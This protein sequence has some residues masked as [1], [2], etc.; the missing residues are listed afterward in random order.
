MFDNPTTDETESDTAQINS[1]KRTSIKTKI[2][3]LRSVDSTP[4]ASADLYEPGDIV[5]CKLGGF[6]WW[7]ALIVCVHI[8]KK[9]VDF[10]F[11]FLFISIDVQLK[12]EYTQKH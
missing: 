8:H 4:D 9:N 11:V 5:W 3:P 2:K 6:P 7:P 12:V 1:N 10:I